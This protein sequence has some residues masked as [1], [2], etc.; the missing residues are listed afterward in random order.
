MPMSN[1]HHFLITSIDFGNY[2]AY[3]PYALIW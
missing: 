3:L 2:L 1:R